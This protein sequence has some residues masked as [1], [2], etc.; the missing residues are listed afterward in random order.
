M[1]NRVVFLDTETTGLDASE[2]HRIVEIAC[3]DVI[4]RKLTDQS[5]HL[6]LNPEREISEDAT[7]IHGI[8]N[9]MVQDKPTFDTVIEQLLNY[10]RDV[11]VVAH[12]ASF[13]LEFINAEITRCNDIKGASYPLFDHVCA[14]VTDSLAMAQKK[15]PGRRN[16]LNALCQRLEIDASERVFHGA[17]LDASLLA[18]VWLKLTGGQKILDL[19]A[20]LYDPDQAQMRRDDSK[21]LRVIHA[22]DEEVERH[23]RYMEN[24][25]TEWENQQSKN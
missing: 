5:F 15:F 21:P 8:D 1:N 11:E 16:N 4:D 9:A 22:T 14:K 23:N 12:N 13:D 6:Y 24:L 7:Q 19:Q 17:L 25:Q 18:Q 10:V 2:G 3:I 20:N